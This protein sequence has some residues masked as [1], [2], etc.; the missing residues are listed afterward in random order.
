LQIW[1]YWPLQSSLFSP[2]ITTWHHKDNSA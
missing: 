2:S 1:S